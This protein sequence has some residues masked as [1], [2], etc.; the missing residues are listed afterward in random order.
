MGNDDNGRASPPKLAKVLKAA[1][2]EL[3]VAHGD[4]LVDDQ[5]LRIDVDRDRKPKTHIHAGR[6]MPNRR[7]NEVTD[8]RE[9]DDL[10]EETIGLATRQTENRCVQVD[11]L[12]A[13]QVRME[14]RSQL[15]KCRY[16]SVDRDLPRRRAIDASDDAKQRR[17]ARAV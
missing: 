13:G 15:K 1:P 6:I 8:T 16:V 11:V 5:D 9:V 4:N 3:F 12:S 2:L 10:I 7:V 14:A 17:L